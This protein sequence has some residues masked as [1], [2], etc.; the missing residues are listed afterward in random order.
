[1]SIV[2]VCLFAGLGPWLWALATA[3]LTPKHQRLW[4]LTENIVIYTSFEIPNMKAL[5]HV[6]LLFGDRLQSP[7]LWA[8]PL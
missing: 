2:H 7:R 1:M 5:V 8:L 3:L 4:I 6:C